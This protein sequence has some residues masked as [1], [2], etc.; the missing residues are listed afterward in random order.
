M[1]L[2]LTECQ[3]AL[4]LSLLLRLRER[5][6]PVGVLG[7]APR[8]QTGPPVL[9]Y[10]MWVPA[11]HLCLCG[12]QGPTDFF[13]KGQITDISVS[14]GS[15]GLCHRH[16]ALPL[17]CDHAPVKRESQTLPRSARTR[18]FVLSAISRY[19]SVAAKDAFQLIVNTGILK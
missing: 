15:C 10:P 1:V 5:K 3:K 6:L 9:F 14:A 19:I 4:K 16:P 8:R 13:F 2:C 7:A 18:G 11:V 17:P 12:P